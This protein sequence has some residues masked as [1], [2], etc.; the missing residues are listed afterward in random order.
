MERPFVNFFNKFF[1]EDRGFKAHKFFY[2]K[3]MWLANHRVND[4]L[5]SFTFK[6]NFYVISF[7]TDFQANSIIVTEN[8]KVLEEFDYLPVEK[9]EWSDYLTSHNGYDYSPYN[10]ISFSW[11]EPGCEFLMRD[12]ST[13]ISIHFYPKGF[14]DIN[15]NPFLTMVY[16]KH[17]NEFDAPYSYYFYGKRVFYQ[18]PSLYSD[19]EKIDE[20]IL[21]TPYPIESSTW[22]MMEKQR[23][24]GSYY[25]DIP[26]F[27]ISLVR[28]EKRVNP[29]K[30]FLASINGESINTHPRYS[31]VVYGLELLCW[32]FY[33]KHLETDEI[34]HDLVLKEA[35]FED[36]F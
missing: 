24:L 7:C 10:Q 22:D 8:F 36:I 5:F 26:P 19:G 32:D 30:I 33:G 20:R 17:E 3:L 14:V 11:T 35:V 13:A 15:G 6:G 21:I 25:K 2:E 23:F 4:N 1:I 12:P 34:P 18:I 16:H 31:G 28:L 29:E 9:V 27:L